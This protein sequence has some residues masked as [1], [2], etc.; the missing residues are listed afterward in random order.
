MELNTESKNKAFKTVMRA[1]GR[2]GPK[3]KRQLSSILIGPVYSNSKSK[4]AGEFVKGLIED[5]QFPI[6]VENGKVRRT[7]LKKEVVS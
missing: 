7:D 2:E 6:E 3:E 4:V 1:L 5:D